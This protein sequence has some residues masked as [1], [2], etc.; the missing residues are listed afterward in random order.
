[1]EEPDESLFKASYF[2]EKALDLD[3]MD[4]HLEDKLFKDEFLV[5]LENR[6]DGPLLLPDRDELR[7]ESSGPPWLLWEDKALLNEAELLDEHALRRLRQLPPDEVLA[8]EAMLLLD[9]DERI[10]EEPPPPPPL[11]LEVDEERLLP[12]NL[13]EEEEDLG[14]LQ[15]FD[16]AEVLLD[17][18]LVEALLGMTFPDELLVMLFREELLLLFASLAR[19]ISLLLS[20][21]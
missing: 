16:F 14:K 9:E 21:V 3:E 1:M 18:L 12:D 15:L 5:D 8:V 6:D 17:R 11:E 13:D 4:L 7:P 20:P 19:G 10:E 2:E